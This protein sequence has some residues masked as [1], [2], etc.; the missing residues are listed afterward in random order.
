MHYVIHVLALSAHAYIYFAT[1]GGVERRKE[2]KQAACKMKA[3]MKPSCAVCTIALPVS[4][5]RCSIN[6]AVSASNKT[7]V[8]YLATVIA[9]VNAHA[10][11][12]LAKDEM[13]GSH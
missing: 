5:Q 1:W 7:V 12:H 9:K 4:K 10:R 2:C 8:E 3:R 6:P 11:V 13:Y